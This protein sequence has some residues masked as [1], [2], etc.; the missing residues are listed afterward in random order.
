MSKQILLALID[1]QE[2]FFL[3]LDGNASGDDVRK[4]LGT[5][6]WRNEK[7]DLFLTEV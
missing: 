3:F 1:Y 2:I 5:F 4:A 6:F 7:L